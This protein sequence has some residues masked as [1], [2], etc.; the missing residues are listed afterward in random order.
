MTSAPADAASSCNSSRESCNSQVDRDLNSR[1]TRKTRSGRLREVS[2]SA[3]KS[4]YLCSREYTTKAGKLKRELEF[5]SVSESGLKLGNFC[6]STSRVNRPPSTILLLFLCTPIQGAEPGR[7]APAPG[8]SVPENI[9]AELQKSSATLGS[10]IEALRQTL[11]TK[12]RLLALL[13]DVEIF[14]KAVE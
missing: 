13:P 9:R 11:R 1:P 4:D 2:I 8:I 10:R 14:H 7:Y 6:W 3:F 12:P 5:L